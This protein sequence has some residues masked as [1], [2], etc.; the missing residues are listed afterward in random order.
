MLERPRV[1]RRALTSDSR[2]AGHQQVLEEREISE[3]R[4][5]R[6]TFRDDRGAAA[7]FFL[8]LV[9]DQQLSCKLAQVARADVTTTVV[10][11]S[12]MGRMTAS[13]KANRGRGG[14]SRHRHGR[15]RHPSTQ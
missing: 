14:S 4:G 6:R 9:R 8:D 3:E 5:S 2:G 10:E 13:R 12:R 11:A 1:R 15:F 7:P